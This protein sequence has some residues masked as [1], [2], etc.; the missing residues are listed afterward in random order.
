M[1]ADTLWPLDERGW[2]AAQPPAFR[3]WMLENGRWQHYA[4][5]QL[6]YDFGEEADGLYGLG[7][8][9]LEVTLPLVG[10]EAVTV[11]R[12][13]P[14][15]WL[16]E[17]ALLARAPRAVSLTAATDAR[18]FRVRGAR[19]RALVR[20]RP[21]TWRH[22]YELSHINATLAVTLLAEAL[23]LSPRARLARMLLRLADAEGRVV[24]RQEELARLIG[25]TRSS[26]QRALV[27]LTETGA[28]GRGYGCL[29]V[30]DR[31]ALEAIR[32]EA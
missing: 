25:M 20:A 28:V 27:G 9:A 30:H 17:S 26:L 13:E 11:H 29:I 16:G 22:F 32:G 6:I 18:V 24:A 1:K 4:P 10:D 5:G 31:A 3:E 23:A 12:A 15:F 2:L 14:G 8:G 21:E 7:G 19:I